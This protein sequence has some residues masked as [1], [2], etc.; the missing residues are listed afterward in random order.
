[1]SLFDRLSGSL[2]FLVVMLSP[3]VAQTVSC[4]MTE[5]TNAHYIAAAITLTFLDYGDVAI[6]DEIVTAAGRKSVHGAVS[7][8]SAQ[9]L[10]IVWEVRNVPAD[11]AEFRRYDPM[12]QMRLTIQKLDG[13]ATLTANDV[14]YNRFSYRGGGMCSFQE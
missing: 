10:S 9:R 14:L 8:E 12:L 5:R 6:Q 7:R 4:V 3:A 11:P 2:A 1:M 13:A